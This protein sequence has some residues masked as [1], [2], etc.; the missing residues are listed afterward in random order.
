MSGRLSKHFA[1]EE[2]VLEVLSEY[3]SVGGRAV[4]ME[5]R[6]VEDLFV[7]SISLIEMVMALNELFGV[8]IPEGAVGEWRTV[9]DVCNTLNDLV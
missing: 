7:E 9:K 2:Q 1:I 8:E 5:C 6:L 3:F 4:V